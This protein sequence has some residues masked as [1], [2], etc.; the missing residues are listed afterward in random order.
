MTTT[1]DKI[2]KDIKEKH[3]C[4]APRWRF[5]AKNWVIWLIFSLA[6]FV[7]ALSFAAMLDILVNHDWDIYFRLHK[8]FWQF[9]L[10]SLPYVWIASIVIFSWIAYYDFVHTRGGYRYAAYRVVSASILASLV[11]GILFFYS[12]F[13]KKIDQVLDAR[14]PF[15]GNININRKQ[16]WCHPDEGL[17]GGEIVKMHIDDSDRF[18][19]KDCNGR[20]WDIRK[21]NM[22]MKPIIIHAGERIKIIGRE[23]EAE[24][25]GFEAEE[26]RQW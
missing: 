10:M 22:Q 24:A 7:A 20:E 23:I 16:M 8:T 9:L 17:L 5:L 18:I 12:G 15:Y 19:V 14:M 13:G 26:F 11:L 21:Q 4:P 3:I 25:Q 6:L 1:S 2:L